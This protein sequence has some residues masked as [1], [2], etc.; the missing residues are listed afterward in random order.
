[1]NSPTRIVHVGLGR[2]GRNWAKI[3]VPTVPTVETVAWVDTSPDALA[4]AQAELGLPADRCFSSLED[5]L[6][7][8][9]AD[10]ILAPVILPAHAPVI[11]AGVRAG[12]H[13]LIEKP[14]APTLKEAT[15]LTGLAEEAGIILH[16]SQN[17]RFFPGAA[18]ARRLLSERH[19]GEVLSV[20][21]EFH[22]RIETTHYPDVPDI[23]L[24]DMAIHHWDLLRVL[25]QTP[26]R[27]V[28]FWTRSPA[29]SPFA[30]DAA[31][32]GMIR[33]DNGAVATYRGNEA[34]RYPE[35]PWAG[36][37]RV[38]CE[39]GVIVF[40]SRLGG[41]NRPLTGE[42]VTVTKND[43][44]PQ[45][46]PLDPLPHYGRAGT[47]N[48]FALT[49]QG[50]THPLVSTARDNLGTIALMEAIVRSSKNGGQSTPVA[51]NFE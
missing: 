33:F 41:P 47:L 48:A 10:A 26:P 28:T 39:D 27:E 7:R 23:L 30:A 20:D 13:V 44:G 35:T 16:V 4:A 21:I 29:G 1:M 5:A 50:K 40:S 9:D 51:R 17:Y 18:T 19:L 8:V 38:E 14:F 15:R 42:Y 45:D 6:A 43:G 32:T 25:V 31:G 2:W 49:L 46:Y 36:H 24:V 3:I 11:E 34:S 37:W 12:K 22:R